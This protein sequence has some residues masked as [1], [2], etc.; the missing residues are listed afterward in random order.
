MLGYFLI[1]VIALCNLLAMKY[2]AIKKV[3]AHTCITIPECNIIYKWK[4]LF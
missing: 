4:D 3:L 2:K 1:P